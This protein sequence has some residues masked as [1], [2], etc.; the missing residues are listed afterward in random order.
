MNGYNYPLGGISALYLSVA[1]ESEAT[2]TQ[3]SLERKID[4]LEDC[5]HYT[6]KVSWVGYSPRVE[7]QLT[8]VTAPDIDLSAILD[9][10]LRIGFIA[11]IEFNSGLA[12]KVGWSDKAKGDRSLKLDSVTT[13]LG[14]SRSSKPQKVWCFSCTDDTITL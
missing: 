14:E 4:I 12:I 2:L 3:G 13:N 9:Q 6:Q 10:G 7:H 11:W 8:V 5:S 1:S